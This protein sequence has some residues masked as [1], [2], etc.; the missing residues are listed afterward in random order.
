[1]P[2]IPARITWIAS[3]ALPSRVFYPSFHLAALRPKF[4]M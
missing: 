4:D 2:S 3:S 1:M